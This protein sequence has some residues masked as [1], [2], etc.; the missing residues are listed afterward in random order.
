MNSSFLFFKK[1]S[2]LNMSGESVNKLTV[3]FSFSLVRKHL[4]DNSRVRND[5]KDTTGRGRRSAKIQSRAFI[6]WGSRFIAWMSLGYV[7]INCNGSVRKDLK[8]TTGRQRGSA[9]V[10]S[11]AVMVWGSR[12]IAWMSLG[13]VW[14]NCNGQVHLYIVSVEARI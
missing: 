7:W 5:L 12:F 1:P 13:Y 14:L 3:H 10:R 2:R 9:K 8:D 6:V 11:R 4:K